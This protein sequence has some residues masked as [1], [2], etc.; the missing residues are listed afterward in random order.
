MTE[1]AQGYLSLSVGLDHPGES[2]AKWLN[3]QQ[4]AVDVA[5]K[6]MGKSLSDGLNLGAERAKADAEQAQRAFDMASKAATTASEKQ[7]AAARKVQIAEAK[8]TETREKYAKDSSQVLTAE[9]RLATAKGA[10]AK[11]SLSVTAAEAKQATAADKVKVALDR[12]SKAEQEAAQKSEQSVSR[13]RTALKSVAT[14]VNPFAGMP[15][16]A[17]TAGSSSGR[18]FA[19]GFKTS[20]K[21]G[22]SEGSKGMF[23]GLSGAARTAAAGLGG[24]FAITQ[25]K[26]WATDSIGAFKSVAGQSIALQ[27]SLGGTVEDASR[28]RVALQ[29][30]GV[31]ADQAAT[32]IRLFAKNVNSMA[33]TDVKAK[34][35]SDAKA[36]AYRSQIAVLQAS[37]KHTATLAARIDALKA[38]EDAARSSASLSS[39][40]LAKMGVD[41]H[42][43][44]G[45]LKPMSAILPQVAD[46]FKEMPDGPEKT[47]AA[48]KLFGRNGADMIK[49]LNKGSAGIKELQA[50]SDKYGLTVSKD[51]VSAVTKSAVAQRQLDAATM[52]LKVSFGAQLMPQLTKVV[53][54]LNEKAIPAI[55]QMT[56]FMSR[57]KTAVKNVAIGI[58]V[59]IGVLKT[60]EIVQ[61]AINLVMGANPF[62]LVAVA[63]AA[64]VA[65]FIYAYK[66]SETFRNV[67]NSVLNGVKKVALAVGSWFAGPFLGF[68][69]AIPGFFTSLWD[70]VKAGFS[71]GINAVVNFVKAHWATIL[72]VLLGPLGLLIGQIIKHWAQIKAAFAAGISAV[73]GVIRTVGSA[74]SGAWNTIWNGV[75]NSWVFKTMNAVFSV[76]FRLAL[77]AIRVGLAAIRAV[78]NAVWGAI[79]AY[80]VTVWTAIKII[81]HGA[82]TLVRNYIIPVL[83]GI[84]AI[85]NAVW[86]AISRFASSVWHGISATIHAVWGAVA[87]WVGGRLA[88]LRNTWVAVWSAIRNFVIPIWASISAVIRSVLSAIT[89]F[90]AGRIANIRSNWTNGFNAVRNTASR[91]MD[92]VH[93]AIKTVMGKI[94]GVFSSGVAAI[95]KAWDGL[96]NVA[97]A[98]VKFVVNTVL[99]GGLIGGFNWVANKLGA[100]PI[101]PITLPHGFAG[102]GFVD[103]PWSAQNRDPYLGMS[104]QGAFRF[105]GEEFIAN[106]AA[107]AKSRGLL[108]AINSGQLNDKMLGFKSGGYTGGRGHLTALAASKITAAAQSLGWMLQLAQ[109]GW[110][111]PNGLSGTSHAGDAVDVSGPAGGTRLWS[112]RDALRRQNWAAWV[113]GP[114]ENFSWHVHAVPGPGAGTPRGSAVWQWS[115]YLAGGGGLHGSG[116][117]DPYA[118]PSSGGSWLSQIGSAVSGLFG[119]FASPVDWIKDRFKSL[120]NVVSKFGDNAFTQMIAKVPVKLADAAIS[121][122]TSLF[123]LSSGPSGSSSNAESWRGVVKQ[124][125]A[126]SGIGGG[127]SDEDKWLRQ[128][129]SESSGNPNLIQ[130]SALRDINVLRGDPARGLVQVPGVT[131]ADFGRDMGGFSTNWMNPLKNLIV[132]MRAAAAQH[133]NWRNVIGFWHGYASGTDSALPGA[134]WLAEEGP[135]LVVGRQMANLTAGSRVYNATQTAQMLGGGS[136]PSVMIVKDVNNELIGRVRIESYDQA[137]NAIDDNADK[138]ARVGG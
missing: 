49:F 107:T 58:G 105:E 52:G 80:L 23:S 63:V 4:K 108:E 56:D 10:A 116:T 102:G 28:M 114:A 92:A 99:N 110:N 89:G 75:R 106:R 100:T 112:I 78:W 53:V 24:M 71:T 64:L 42:D 35:S 73:V 104:P 122:V 101:K 14:R 125:L 119:K 8:L 67:I 76:T 86:S 62:V 34:A 22:V 5:G 132:G 117:P 59:L 97:K 33:A 128:I 88:S 21:R 109:Q 17:Q 124:A 31:S 38:K 131:W 46:K 54:L 36:T 69:K 81:V 126:R 65:A 120:G 60:L 27:K 115:D 84:R 25:V 90:I 136:G 20:G 51:Q 72:A 103:L 77:V 129:M 18:S 47:A 133:K 85:W 123:N 70:K 48:M 12:Q 9:D 30:S 137:L 98:P 118:K 50:Q 55:K 41:Y 39:S 11:A 111:A 45:N 66:H 138:I 7:E 96:Q 16:E 61:G 121:K 127:K 95:K 113:R 3:S 135:E 83:Y 29:L 130:S 1:L 94:G 79:R 74:I 26:S 37:G 44:A 43:A 82:M 57:H 15:A 68:F 40:V 93:S 87:G 13:I 91:V 134:A 32:H 6:A 2:V 19:S